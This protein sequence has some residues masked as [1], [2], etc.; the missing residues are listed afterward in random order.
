MIA[1]VALSAT[2]YSVSARQ[3]QI[4]NDLSI[5]ETQSHVF[6]KHI[7]VR[8]DKTLDEIEATAA[9]LPEYTGVYMSDSRGKATTGEGR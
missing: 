7:I 3:N 8:G 1:V 4:T 2:V 6:S 9:T 5:A